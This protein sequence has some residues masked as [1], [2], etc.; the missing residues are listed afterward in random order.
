MDRSTLKDCREAEGLSQEQL[1]AAVGVKSKGYLSRIESGAEPA[2]IRLALRIERFF[3]GLVRAE[4][5]L[6]REDAE[7]LDR[8]PAPA[9]A[10]DSPA[11][12]DPA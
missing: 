3:N 12:E 4:S 2:G 7:L 11:A 6:A 10:E 5:L 8:L 1:G 9:S